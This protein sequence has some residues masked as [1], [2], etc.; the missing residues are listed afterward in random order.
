MN[1]YRITL[2]LYLDCAGAAITPQTLNFSNNC[3]ATFSLGNVPLV[4]V[5][6]VSQLCGSQLA[7]STCNGGIEP[8]MRHYRF[9]T[10]IPLAPCNSWLMSWNICCRSVTQNVQGVPGMYVQATLNNAGGLCDQSPQFGDTSIPY[11]CVNTP[12]SYNPMV[13]DADGNTLVYSFINAQFV[14]PSN[15]TYQPGFTAGTPITGVTLNP[16][17][18]QINFTPTVTGRYVVV[19]QVASYNSLGQL[20]GTVMR[21]FL[22]V[23]I[24]CV[25]P[26][27][28]N[29]GP[30]NI[31]S[32]FITSAT[33]IEVCNGIPFCVDMS[34]ADVDPLAIITLTSQIT[35]QLPGS[36]FTVN[37]NNPVVATLCWTPVLALSPVTALVAVND[38]ACPL[39]NL[40]DY[41]LTIN[42]VAVPPVPPNPGTSAT[43]S[44]C[45]GTPSFSLFAQLGGGPQAGG[46]WTG[47]G[48]AAHSATFNPA[49]DAFGVY[50][51]TV[52][53]G[54]HNASATVTVNQI[55]ASSA[56]TNGS[57][58]ICSN[59]AAVALIASLGGSPAAG[60]AW[61]G[62][63]PVVGGQYNPVTMNPGVYTYTVT[64]APPCVNSTATVTVTENP[65]P[66]AGTNANLAT[67][68]NGA[69][70][71]L[72]AQLG[73]AQAGGAWSGPSPVVGGNYNPVTM[74]PGVYTYTLT[75]VAPCAN[76]SATVTV[77]E[78][79]ATSAGTNG[80]LTVCSNGAAVS[81]FTQLGGTPQAGG[82]WTGPSAVV[83]GNYDPATMNAGVYTYTVTGVAPC[84]NASATVTVTENAATN[85]GTNGALTVCSNGAAVSLFT[86]LGGTPQVGGAWSGPSAVVGGNYGKSHNDP[87]C[88]PTP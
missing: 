6:E 31:T 88:T 38:N 19:V 2:D 61:S 33:S 84:T 36:T 54:C 58:T 59:G 80:A 69:V 16:A 41:A 3:G 30:T 28:T 87:A 86:Q 62:P 21:D 63:S 18:G 5:E 23:V 51:Y 46:S 14:G 52:G 22:F 82:A 8:G 43:V 20:I 65:A 81:L 40:S 55:A 34:F 1:Q 77:T 15:V 42:V 72:L 71:S 68:S 85:A 11:V 4:L 50:T 73:G 57:L 39:Q 37:G 64:N 67:C 74:D 70:V 47:P 45:A 60:G 27:A 32:G 25:D 17:T 13:T 78:N 44:S 75:G 53:N 79:T 10:T 9:Q 35:A 48:G 83:G 29:L 7:N 49:L 26:P 12:V 24:P 66:N 56:G 76:A